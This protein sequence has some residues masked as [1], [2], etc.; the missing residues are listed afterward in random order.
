[1][2]IAPDDPALSSTN[3]PTTYRSISSEAEVDAAGETS[4]M[5]IGR[6][7]I[8]SASQLPKN[9]LRS[10]T[11]SNSKSSSRTG[12]ASKR[13]IHRRRD[14]HRHG[15]NHNYKPNEKTWLR[16]TLSLNSS[17]HS[18]GRFSASNTSLSLHSMDRSR[19]WDDSKHSIS[20]VASQRQPSRLTALREFP[21][22]KSLR[23]EK[24]TIKELHQHRDEV[25]K[26]ILLPPESYHDVSGSCLRSLLSFSFIQCLTLL[27][28]CDAVRFHSNPLL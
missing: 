3:T 9:S 8:S 2:M 23:V 16:D 14:H 12:L 15:S 22:Q 17:D 18:R 13:K 20:S 25:G 6:L 4:E 5:A 1:M 10:S 28:F 7:S 19:R 24:T 11:H 26:P 27:S 21:S